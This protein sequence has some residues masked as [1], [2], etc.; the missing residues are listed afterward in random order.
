MK[1]FTSEGLVMPAFHGLTEA[2]IKQRGA[3]SKN[4][5][6]A[7]AAV[8]RDSTENQGVMRA[9]GID[10][11][12]QGVNNRAG[13]VHDLSRLLVTRR[14]DAGRVIGTDLANKGEQIT[15]SSPTGRG[16]IGLLD[17]FDILTQ[18]GG[19]VKNIQKGLADRLKVQ[20]DRSVDNGVLTLA[21]SNI[22]SLGAQA[23]KVQDSTGLVLDA[24]VDGL[25][26]LEDEE[27]GQLKTDANLNLVHMM[28]IH[29]KNADRQGLAEKTPA[30]LKVDNR[31]LQKGLLSLEQVE[32]GQATPNRAA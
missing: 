4:A 13:A 6:L 19:D 16:L 29:R 26:R 7:V 32:E 1:G 17:L 12:N 11:L 9:L 10:K 18:F 31:L 30:L 14:P 15:K 24:L 20:T 25:E 3:L 5:A 23:K 28:K 8:G 21:S 2:A 27:S 22:E